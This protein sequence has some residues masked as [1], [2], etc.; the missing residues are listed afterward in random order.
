[1][2]RLKS[3]TPASQIKKHC[4]RTF[5]IIFILYEDLLIENE[6]KIP[7]HPVAKTLGNQSDP[8]SQEISDQIYRNFLTQLLIPFS[9]FIIVIIEVPLR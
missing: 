5:Y 3:F 7:K 4:M 8:L 2:E 1:M 6:N 9:L